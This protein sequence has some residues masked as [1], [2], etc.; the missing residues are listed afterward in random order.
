MLNDQDPAKA[1]RF[2]KTMLQMDKLIIKDL[3]AAYDQ[4]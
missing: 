1:E 2:M 4:E 3:K